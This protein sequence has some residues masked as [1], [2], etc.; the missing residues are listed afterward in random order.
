[1]QGV[2]QALEVI[3]LARDGLNPELRWLG[4]V[5]NIADMRTRH[6][7]E[8]F[9][10]LREHVG[11]KLFETTVRAVDRLR[12]VLRA[13]G[14]DPR[15]PPRPRRRLPRAGRRA[16]AA[17]E[18]EGRP[19]ARAGAR[20]GRARRSSVRRRRAGSA[21]P[22]LARRRV[23]AVARSR[24]RSLAVAPAAATTTAPA[25]P[26]RPR[27]APPPER[28]AS[29]PPRP[30]AAARRRRAALPSGPVGARIVRRTQ[31]RRSPGGRGRARDRHDD[32]LRLRAG[33]VRRRAA[34]PLARRAH[35]S[36]CPT[37]ARRWIPQDSAELR[38]RALPA[39]RRPLRAA[40]SSCAARVASCAA[41][42][43][44]SASR[45]RA[46]P[47]GRFAVT[48]TLRIGEGRA[49][50]TAA[51]RSRSPAASPTSRRAGR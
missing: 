22:R 50:S 20:R 29:P 28:R 49:R 17:P 4:V 34:R 27:R 23:A 40:A 43:S 41:S 21:A 46:T 42:A 12:R 1:M 14:L 16:P 11:E 36:T 19:Q 9:A 33:A 18:A 26:A 10:T 30:A 39:R 44:R 47:T 45:R 31:L 48:D 3:E 32:R 51:A 24:R 7:R 2:E 8:A 37:R 25:P 6:S 38:A 13:R 5:F 35:A 15:P